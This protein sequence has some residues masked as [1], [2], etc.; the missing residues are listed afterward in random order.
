[1]KRLLRILILIFTLQAPSWADDIRDLQI[2]GMSIGDSLLEYYSKK[3]LTTDTA[4]FYK[5][6]TYA[7]QRIKAASESLFQSVTVNYLTKD[8]TFKAVAI[9]G[10]LI[11]PNNINDC[12]KKMDEVKESLMKSLP[13][14][15]PE[16]KKINKNASYGVY[17]YISFIFDLGDEISVSCYDYDKKYPYT[18]VFRLSF[19]TIEFRNWIDLK[20]YK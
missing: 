13:N 10:N 11:F 16:K 4:D 3:I 17:T 12:Y 1:M 15:I 18:D 6:N 8:K 20:A 5:D 14:I 9:A 2:E 19:E 7:T